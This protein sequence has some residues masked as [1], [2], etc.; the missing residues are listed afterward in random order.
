MK[1]LVKITAV[2]LTLCIILSCVGCNKNNADKKS[3]ESITL[4]YFGLGDNLPALKEGMG[5]FVEA[6][7]KTGIKLE[8]FLSQ[9]ASDA[10]QALTTMMA[11]GTL[12][13]IIKFNNRSDISKYGPSGALV[14]LNDLINEKDTPNLCAYFKEHPE[15]EK[16]IRENDGNIYYIP[17]LQGIDEMK[18]SQ[19]WFIRYDWLEKLGMKVPTTVDELYDVLYAFATK[20]PNGNG[21]KDEVPFFSRAKVI[22]SLLYLW[23]A[24]NTFY[25]DENDKVNYGPL[26]EEYKIA[27]TNIAKWYSEGLI[28]KEIFSR[29]NARD[30]LLA[31]NQGGCSFDWAGSTASFSESMKDSVPGINF[32]WM[33]PPKNVNGEMRSAE[34]RTL[35][36]QNGWS[37]SSTN[38]YP[39]DTIRYFDFWFSEDGHR[40]ANYGIEGEHYDI[41][42]GEPKFKEEL[43]HGERPIL[44]VLRDSGAQWAFGFEQ[45]FDYE[46]QWL[47]KDALACMEAYQEDVE[48]DRILPYLVY[49]DEER[50]RV[51]DV[52]ADVYTS[53]AETSQQW[54]LG[55]LDIANSYDGF[56]KNLKGNG[57]DE[58]LSIMQTAYDRSK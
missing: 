30:V 17:F 49:T 10:G 40:L 56:L 55:S 21:L 33:M 26:E 38:K 47:N 53:V 32:N 41:V 28:D 16:E 19:T 34:S 5:V 46:R 51:D 37:I 45:D 39:E 31:N 29:N 4:S 14:P 42:D 27:Y 3:G 36:A 57:I 50:E 24:H 11:S 22:N 23:G 1:K 54:I 48:F 9:S 25:I 44:D 7:K 12:A 15:V 18:T 52:M 35:V 8:N 6:E 2:L 20:D 13:D 58:V 43:I